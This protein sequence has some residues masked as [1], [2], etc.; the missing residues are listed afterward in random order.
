MTCYQT[1]R[2]P[3]FVSWMLAENPTLSQR[4]RTALVKKYE[5][6]VH[7]G[8]HRAMQGSQCAYGIHSG[9][10]SQFRNPELRDPNLT[11]QANLP[12]LCPEGRHHLYCKGQNR[13]LFH[14]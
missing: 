10:E 5:L 13:E 2:V 7:V 9:S 4:Q 11:F 3:A 1:N 8:S 12:N 6:Q 14:L